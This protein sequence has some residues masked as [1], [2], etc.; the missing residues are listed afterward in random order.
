MKAYRMTINDRERTV[1]VGATQRE[2]RRLRL[3]GTVSGQQVRNAGQIVTGLAMSPA[4]WQ[5]FKAHNQPVTLDWS[6]RKAVEAFAMDSL[7]RD[8][9]RYLEGLAVQLRWEAAGKVATA[10][11][12]AQELRQMLRQPIGIDTLID[13][14]EEHASR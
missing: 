12:T 1:V 13:W 10:S 4:T 3:T 5:A 7:T 8:A 14:C 6:D 9:G 11:E 2:E